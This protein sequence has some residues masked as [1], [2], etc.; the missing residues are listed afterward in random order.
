MKRTQGHGGEVVRYQSLSVRVIRRGCRGCSPRSF[1]AH[2]GDNGVVD[3]KD[4]D[5]VTGAY[6]P[7]AWFRQGGQ[8]TGT[9]PR[10][11]WF[12]VDELREPSKPGH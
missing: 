8:R 12:R 1:Q 4:G 3:D 10:K 6:Y 2:D 7:N 9:G 5:D 11:G